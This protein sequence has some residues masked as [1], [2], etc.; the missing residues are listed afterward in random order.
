VPV[1]VERGLGRRVAEADLDR[2]HRR[3]LGAGRRAGRPC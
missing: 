3:V 2:L 1:D